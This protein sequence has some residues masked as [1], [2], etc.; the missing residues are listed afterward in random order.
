ML[1][2]KCIFMDGGG[3]VSELAGERLS[4]EAGVSEG[5]RDADSC[6]RRTEGGMH[7]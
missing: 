3:D 6:C 5:L 1:R 2:L 7:A 4:R